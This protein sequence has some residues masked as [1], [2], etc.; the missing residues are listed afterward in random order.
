[1]HHSNPIVLKLPC[2]KFHAPSCSSSFSPPHP[3]TRFK[4]PTPNR[5]KVSMLNLSLLS[6]LATATSELNMFA[7]SNV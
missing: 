3:K 1:M 5:V 4:K 6:K 2:A 7:A